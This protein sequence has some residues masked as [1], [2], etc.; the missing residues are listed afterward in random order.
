MH[1]D[2]KV[3]YEVVRAAPVKA[4]VERS[5][6]ASMLVVGSRG[7]GGFEGLHVGSTALQLMG[8]SHAPILVTR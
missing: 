6:G 2:V 5:E 3:D 1:P 8:R 4:L 7:S